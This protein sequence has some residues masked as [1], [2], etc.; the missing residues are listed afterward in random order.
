VPFGGGSLHLF[1]SHI[2]T[3][4]SVEG[5]LE[6]HRAVLALAERACG[7]EPVVLL[8]DFNTLDDKARLAARALLESRGYATPL[9]TGT[10]TW[11]SGPLRYH[12]DWIFT[13][14]LSVRRWGVARVRGISDH[15]P[16]WVEVERPET[17]EARAPGR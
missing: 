12:Y 11:R 9:P 16:V 8:G 1:N 4:A 6:Q 13:R 3:H 17:L 7:S 15:W 10:P 2:D 5:Q 14:H